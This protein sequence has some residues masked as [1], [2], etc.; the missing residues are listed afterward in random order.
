MN[1]TPWWLTAL[2]WA[3]LLALLSAAGATLYLLFGSMDDGTRAKLYLEV[4]KSLLYLI[5]VLLIGAFIAALIKSFDTSKK[6]DKSIHD[7]RNDF[8]VRLLATYQNVLLSRHTLSATGLTNAFG[9]PPPAISSAQAQQYS[10]AAMQLFEAASDLQRLYGDVAKFPDS[11]SAH[12]RLS[13]ALNDMH[14]YIDAIL[15]EYRKHWPTLSTSPN[16][17][18]MKSLDKLIDFTGYHPHNDY[19]KKMA[20]P[21]ESAVAFVRQDLLPLKKTV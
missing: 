1:Y 8:L 12:V 13:Y 17:V 5:S 2:R 10:L 15:I 18:P 6:A 20:T 16:L 3:A 9:T 14:K 21:Y 7:F 11:F 4:S 19:E